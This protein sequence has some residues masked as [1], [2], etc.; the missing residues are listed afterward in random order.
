M[1][2]RRA[3]AQ[4]C[5]ST[6]W[7]AHGLLGSEVAPEAIAGNQRMD[8]SATNAVGDALEFKHLAATM[9]LAHLLKQSPFT[10]VERDADTG[11][12]YT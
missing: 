9:F 12:M 7:E 11:A 10:T 4:P 3:F 8:C 6:A 1:E 5:A 2:W